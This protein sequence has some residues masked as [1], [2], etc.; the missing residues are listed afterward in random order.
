M[1]N[2][3]EA[4][5]EYKLSSDEA[6]LSEAKSLF[7]H[8]EHIHKPGLDNDV[9]AAFTFV[10]NAL[11]I[12]IN[13][14]EKINTDCSISNQISQISQQ[15]QINSRRIKLTGNW[16][17]EASVPLVVFDQKKRSGLRHDGKQKTSILFAK[18][19]VWRTRNT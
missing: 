19:N 12:E 9:I 10:A 5:L 15:T 16:W 4:L 18:P 11:D 6:T 7:G 3:A 17:R 14:V 8:R 13:L 1:D 2:K